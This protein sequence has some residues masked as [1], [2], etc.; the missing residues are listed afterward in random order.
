MK[1]GIYVGPNAPA[2]LVDAVRAGGGIICP[3]LDAQAF[4]WYGASATEFGDVVHPGVR[5]VQLQAAGVESW[6]AAGVIRGN[7]QFT[8]AA[9]CYATAVAEHTLAVLLA[10][11][12]RLHELARAQTWT[13][14]APVSL[15]G[16]TVTIVG[17]G[18]I[19]GALIALLAPFDVQV[20]AVT[21]SGR[22]VVG[23]DESLAPASLHDALRRADYVVLAAPDTGQTR[24]MIGADELALMKSTAWLVNIARGSLVDTG[25]L[26]AALQ[27]GTIGGAA[28]DVTDPEPLPDGHPLWSAPEA[29]IT[30]HSANTDALLLPE[31]AK[32]VKDNTERFIAGR[33]LTGLI[34]PVRGY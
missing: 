2:E 19:G 30:P 6:L 4:I 26:V 5:W 23:A 31:L 7:R 8:S 24:S 20:L 13:K 28:L 21:R 18:G 32:R 1:N 15:N 34:D 9:G 27:S 29:L 11:A 22:Q 10:A 33:P 16:S 12:R 17:A 25:A 14:P 3:A